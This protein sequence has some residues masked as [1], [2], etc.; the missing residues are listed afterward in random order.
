M[1][2]GVWAIAWLLLHGAARV[3]GVDT[4]VVP[5]ASG[6]VGTA[7][8]AL[9]ESISDVTLIGVVGSASRLEEARRAGYPQ[10]FVRDDHLVD[11]VLVRLDT[12]GQ[13]VHR[14]CLGDEGRRS[15]GVWVRTA[16]AMIRSMTPA[17]SSR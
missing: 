7:L 14:L 10:T 17:R 11:K 4:I 1:V 12:D 16:N 13:A 15:L 2:P 3:R 8:A 9:A 5:S 6:A